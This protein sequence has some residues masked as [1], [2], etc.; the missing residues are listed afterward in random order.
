M[1]DFLDLEKSK[2]ISSAI[3]LALPYGF[4][5][6]WTKGFGEQLHQENKYFQSLHAMKSSL[7]FRKK[8]LQ[9]HN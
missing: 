6:N 7:T 2:M 5:G 8:R 3:F 9:R 1:S 4:I